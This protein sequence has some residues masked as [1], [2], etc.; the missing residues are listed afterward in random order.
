MNAIEEKQNSTQEEETRKNVMNAKDRNE[1]RD[2]IQ[3][4]EG[5]R[6]L[7]VK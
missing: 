7:W 5:G 3:F 1:E 2:S 6:K 4:R